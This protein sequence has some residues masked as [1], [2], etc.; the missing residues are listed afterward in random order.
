ME[1]TKK[2]VEKLIEIKEKNTFINH[3]M[4]LISRDFRIKGEVSYNKITLWKQGF[5]S[6]NIYPI[7]IFEFNTEMHLINITDK[8]NPIGKILRIVILLPLAIL[9]FAQI[10]NNFDFIGNWK[11]ITLFGIFI[12]LIILLTR[13]VY[14]FE[15]QNQLEMFYDLLDIE[16]EKNKIEK[17]WN[18]KKVITRIFMYPFCIGLILLAIFLLFPNGDLI[19]G[20]GSLGIAGT[21]LFT[22]I[23]ILIR[24]KTTGNT[25]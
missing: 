7:F 20:I 9:I 19:L 25:V 22:D 18:Y 3:L 4:T 16:T 5:W 6:M 2:E 21:Y 12:S 8:Q 24:K 17:E 15:K 14:N 23:K 1:I 13:K 11:F 10:K